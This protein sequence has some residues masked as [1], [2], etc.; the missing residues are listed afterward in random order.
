MSFAARL[1]LS[2][3]AQV[4]LLGLWLCIGLLMYR[5][6]ALPGPFDWGPFVTLVAAA[7]ISVGAMLRADPSALWPILWAVLVTGA[8]ETV[9]LQTGQPFGRYQYLSAAGPTLPGGLP[10]SIVAAWSVLI[11]PAVA[12]AER[13][14]L[15][16]T[17]GSTL[18]RAVTAGL[19]MVAFD[20]VLDPIAVS[21][22]QMWRW[23]KGGAYYGIPSA[24]FVGWF[25]YSVIAALP[26][27]LRR[28]EAPEPWPIWA[29]A[30]LIQLFMAGLGLGHGLHLPVAFGAIQ[31]AL[32]LVLAWRGSSVEGR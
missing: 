6:P 25:C 17:R 19:L 1:R 20:L 8:A 13:F 31:G 30:G 11:L 22:L 26:F 23:V 24:N 28:R 4:A 15:D 7:L 10:I 32:L 18:V 14:W 16:R 12:G 5:V 2:P 21:R 29:V 3:G 9:G 27:F